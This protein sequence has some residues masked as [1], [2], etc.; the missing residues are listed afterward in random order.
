MLVQALLCKNP[1]NF[2]SAFSQASALARESNAALYILFTGEKDAAS[3][4]SWCPD[5]TR[6]EPLL[7]NVLQKVPNPFVYVT[8]DVERGPYRQADYAYRADPLIK[9]RCVPTLLRIRNGEVVGRLNDVQCQSLP[10]L[11]E[12]L[13]GD[14]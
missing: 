7:E 8:C 14:E 5:C 12:F 3:G 2:A 6:A 1:S 9:L 11:E 13:L 4:V 10:T